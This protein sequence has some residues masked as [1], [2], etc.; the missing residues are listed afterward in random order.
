MLRSSTESP[1]TPVVMRKIIVRNPDGTTKLI[2][3]KV[4]ATGNPAQTPSGETPRSAPQKVQV[5]RRP[6]GTLQYQ[7]LKPGMFIP[8]V[9][10][11]F[12]CMHRIFV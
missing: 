8:N 10:H 2:Q 3:K 6:D 1:K 7:G 9:S 5:I 12:L 4:L 11:S